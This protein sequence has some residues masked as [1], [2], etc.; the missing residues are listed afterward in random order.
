MADTLLELKTTPAKLAQVEGLKRINSDLEKLI[1]LAK[2]ADKRI[3]NE[4]IGNTNK[5]G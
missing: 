4:T 3:K 1:E 5:Q 2:R